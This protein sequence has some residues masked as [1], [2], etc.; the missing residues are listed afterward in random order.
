VKFEIWGPEQDT[1]DYYQRL[2]PMALVPGNGMGFVDAVTQLA[3][4]RGVDAG[5]FYDLIEARANGFV[6]NLLAID[7]AANNTSVVFAMEWQG[8]RLLFP[9]DAELKSWKTMS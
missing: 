9:G 5:A 2:L 7:K 8:R 6:D 3:P 1:S 4:P